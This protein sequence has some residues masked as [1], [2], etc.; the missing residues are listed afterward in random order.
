MRYRIA[1]SC[2]KRVQSITFGLVF[3]IDKVNVNLNGTFF[4]FA[5]RYMSHCNWFRPVLGKPKAAPCAKR[6]NGHGGARRPAMNYGRSGNLG[7]S[8]TEIDSYYLT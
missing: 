8:V 5:S 3:N 1:R 7:L 2:Y 6:K 4:F